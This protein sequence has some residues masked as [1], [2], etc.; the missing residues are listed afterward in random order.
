MV[1]KVYVTYNQVHKLCQAS[2]ERI[3]KDFRPNLMIAI[4]GGGYVPARI[5]RSFLKRPGSANIPIQAIG[6]SLYESI[7]DGPVEEPGTKVTRTQW[8]DLSSLEMANL[9]GKNIL[10]V[11]EVDDTRTTLEYAVKELEKDVE[12]AREKLGREGEKTRFSIFVLHN[13]DKPKKGHLPQDM[14]DENRYLAAHTVSDVWICYPWEATDIDEHDRLAE[15]Q[16]A[17]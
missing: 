3:L 7:R 1:E 2:A 13:K 10:I 16:S 5:L 4:G 11:D 9:V 8:L 6:L 14:M 15:S 17:N 12:A